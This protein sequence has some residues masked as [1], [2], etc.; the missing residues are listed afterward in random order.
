MPVDPD[1]C[2]DETV[3]LGLG[4]SMDL[5]HLSHAIFDVALFVSRRPMTRGLP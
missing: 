2:E 5:L 4:S 1:P 3:T